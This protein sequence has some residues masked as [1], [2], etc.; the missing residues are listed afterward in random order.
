MSAAPLQVPLSQLLVPKYGGV[1]L[2]R[3]ARAHPDREIG[4]HEIFYV[5]KGRL[6][7]AEAGRTLDTHAGEGLILWPHRRHYGTEIVPSG[8]EFYW[9]HVVIPKPSPGEPCLVVQQQSHPARPSR[10]LELFHRFLHDQESGSLTPVS[11]H[12]LVLLMLCE[13]AD[14]GTP[15]SQNGQASRASDALAM[16][17]DA[18]IARRFH[19]PISTGSIAR[20]L[21][22][23]PDY[24]GRVYH[25]AFGRTVLQ[26]IAQRRIDDAC[27]LLL[28]EP[29]LSMSEVGAKCGFTNQAWFRRSFHRRTGQSPID[30]RRS[31]ARAHVNS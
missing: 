15:P 5:R 12:A 8:C 6:A 28:E 24:L 11:S 26:G 25:L 20:L 14:Q 7:I 9:L 23:N 1:G 22:C 30:Y 10:L 2:G 3:N 16:R 17:A 27:R 29:G 13:M 18:E 19:L 4:E 21:G 31:H